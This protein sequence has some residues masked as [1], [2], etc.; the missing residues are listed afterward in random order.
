MKLGQGNAADD[1]NH[2]LAK[3]ALDS[4]GAT[5]GRLDVFGE[6]KLGKFGNGHRLAVARVFAELDAGQFLHG[7]RACARGQGSIADTGPR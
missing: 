6:V 7:E 5:Q 4:L 1:R 2:V 3:T